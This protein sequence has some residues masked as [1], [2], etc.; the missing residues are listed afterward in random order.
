MAYRM[1]ER[2]AAAAIRRTYRCT[3]CR[4]EFKVIHQT[5]DEPAPDCPNCAREANL[6]LLPFGK[7]TSYSHAMDY[8]QKMAEEQ[9]GMTNIRD[10]QRAGDIAAMGP[11]AETTARREEVMREV[12]QIAEQTGAP[13]PEV[14][15][16]AGGFW[17]PSNGPQLDT[18]ITTAG[19]AQRASGVDPVGLLEAGKARGITDNVRYDVVARTK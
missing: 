14:A 11:P 16:A 17:S 3:D 4:F 13:P 9:Y 19:A 18:A 6:H 12:M 7:K 2:A 1:T 5:E 15:A 10:N 8:T